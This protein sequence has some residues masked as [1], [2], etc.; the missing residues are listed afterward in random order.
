MIANELTTVFEDDNGCTQ[1]A[2]QAIRAPFH[3][4]FAGPGGCDGSFILAPAELQWAANEPLQDIG[5]ILKQK[6]A[7]Y[8][9][10][11]ADLVQFAAGLS[12]FSIP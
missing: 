11:A 7:A 6:V 8:N 1:A 4:C 2:R 3:D 12:L 10:S 9:V 5:A